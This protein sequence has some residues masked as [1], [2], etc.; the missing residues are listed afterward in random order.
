MA[1][2]VKG[3]KIGIACSFV[4]NLTI[5]VNGFIGEILAEGFVK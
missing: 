1:I 4:R 3:T 5:K 2:L